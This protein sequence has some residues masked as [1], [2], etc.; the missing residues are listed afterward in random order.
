MEKLSKEEML[1]HKLRREAEL[2]KPSANFSANVMKAI[3]VKKVVREYQPLISKNGWI[4]IFSVIGMIFL[5]SFLSTVD[6]SLIPKLDFLSSWSFPKIELSGTMTWAI[7]FVSMFL[8]QIPF[9]KGVL[10]KQWR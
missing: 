7:A 3:A 6:Y 10:E 2:E 9:L 8:L 5:G 1:M 4:V